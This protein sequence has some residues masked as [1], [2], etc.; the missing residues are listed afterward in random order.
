MFRI[1]IL[2]ARRGKIRG[3]HS[4]LRLGY[5]TTKFVRLLV[6]TRAGKLFGVEILSAP[7]KKA[8]E[9]IKFWFRISINFL[10]E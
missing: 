4:R 6:E 8:I 2:G 1:E 5:N 3:N 7:R 10:E 9:S